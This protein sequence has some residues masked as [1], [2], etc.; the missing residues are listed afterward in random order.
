M[1]MRYV[2]GIDFGTSTLRVHRS[3]LSDDGQLEV[4]PQTAPLQGSDQGALPMIIE[5]DSSTRD[6]R[7]YGKPALSNLVAG[8]DNYDNY[9]MAFKPCLGQ[10]KEDL[11]NQGKPAVAHTRICKECGR[12]SSPDASFCPK[13]GKPLPLLEEDSSEVLFRYSQEDAFAWS[14]ALL[15]RVA[16]DLTKKVYGQNIT[17]DNGWKIVTGIPVHWQESTKSRFKKMVSTC[18]SN[19]GVE[20]LTEPEAA[21]RYHLWS[22]NVPPLKANKNVLVVD[23][24]AGTTDFTLCLLS[25]DGKHLIESRTYG[26]RYGGVDFDVALANYAA[27]VLNI[28]RDSNLPL[29]IQQLGKSL[30][31]EFSR[32]LA[33]GQSECRVPLFVTLNGKKY[34]E[35]VGLDKTTFCSDN[36]AGKLLSEFSNMMR[37]AIAKFALSA[38]SIGVVIITGG[39]ASWYFVEST[40]KQL[41]PDAP[42]LIGSEPDEAISKGLAL[43]PLFAADFMQPERGDDIFVTVSMTSAEAKNG[44]KK[45]IEVA[46]KKRTLTIPQGV[47]N[48]QQ[49]KLD[50]KG[51]PGKHGGSAG[52]VYVT[53]DIQELPQREADVDRDVDIE[54]DKVGIEPSPIVLRPQVES[55]P[56]VLP[57]QVESSPSA[58]QPQVES[59]PIVLPPQAESP[60]IV[61]PPQV[62]SPPSALQP[63]VE[64]TP[65]VLP[66]QVEPPPIVSH[67]QNKIQKPQV[68]SVSKQS[69]S[70]IN[71]VDGAEL[72]TIPAGEF[73]MGSNPTALHWAGA[74]LAASVTVLP[75]ALYSAQKALKYGTEQPKHSIVLDAFRIYKFPV[76]VEQYRLFCNATGHVMPDIPYWG[77]VDDCPIV[78]VT[79]DDAVAY[80]NWAEGLLPT[81]AQW[82]KAARGSMGK[83]YPWG[84]TLQFGMCCI[85]QQRV[86]SVGQFSGDR[87]PYGCMDM[88]GN[89]LE[90]CADWF[91]ANYY[92]KSPKYN[93]AG[94]DKGTERVLRGGS[95]ADDVNNSKNTSRC[96]FR[97]A[98][99]P[100]LAYNN[101]GFRVVLPIANT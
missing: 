56:I 33:A 10:A 41:F 73:I 20:L 62:E 17:A 48:G 32:A 57:P 1:S 54:I 53:C 83:I 97:R 87:S 75:L 2:L 63:Q 78:G 28:P 52:D 4:Q 67:A 45:I 6:I 58:L 19:D 35:I 88:A 93:P 14:Q 38:E 71:P 15:Q 43:P 9:V 11:S 91:D 39:G 69:G 72:I 59:T 60:P 26:E 36:V 49:A 98:E 99:S 90:W 3:V 44:C 51:A 86:S 61:L 22:K 96:A 18:F 40:S 50:G 65:I 74:A 46:G 37:R 25:E 8:A 23:F 7:V 13:C 30:K 84:D 24:G 27:D 64:S 16:G 34:S 95:W 29:P 5:V 89:V 101:V 80:A 94:P 21:L 76:T 100:G 66:P 31:E 81:E 85:G 92:E 79:W 77:W 47:K 68:Q 55:S 42:V 12:A 70:K 82:E